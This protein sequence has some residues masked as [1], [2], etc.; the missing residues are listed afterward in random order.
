MYIASK[1]TNEPGHIT[2]RSPYW[3]CCEK[4]TDPR[5]QVTQTDN[6]VKCGHG[7]LRYVS[8]QTDRQTNRQ[9]QTR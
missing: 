3:A 1:S 7:V 6:L 4:K 9:T 2:A 8:G 5:A